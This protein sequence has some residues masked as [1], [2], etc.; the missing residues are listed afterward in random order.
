MDRIRSDLR[1]GRVFEA[2]EEFR[3]G[4]RVREF[5]EYQALYRR[6][7]EE[8]EAFWAEQMDENIELFRRW[9]SVVE[10]HPERVGL[11]SE[12]YLTWFQGAQLNV[13][14]NCLDRHVKTDRRV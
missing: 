5:A 1:E 10:Y 14:Y 9:S 12:P 6:S 2:G 11:S 3:R 4:A 13:S 8:P 7:I